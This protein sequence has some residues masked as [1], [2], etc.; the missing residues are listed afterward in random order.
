MSE[1]PGTSTAMSVEV[2][3][4]AAAPNGEADLSA[5]RGFFRE[6]HCHTYKLLR[7]DLKLNPS[8]V[9]VKAKMSDLLVSDACWSYKPTE[10]VR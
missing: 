9:F 4:H 1:L 6:L 2:I 8:K 7:M 5:Y 3:A 10:K